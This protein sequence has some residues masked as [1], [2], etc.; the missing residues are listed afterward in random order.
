[1]FER[2]IIDGYEHLISNLES[3]KEIINDRNDLLPEQK[4]EA[5]I[6][7]NEVI[8]FIKHYL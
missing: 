4:E 3:T 6:Q 7:L 2:I 1:M 5:I 8:I